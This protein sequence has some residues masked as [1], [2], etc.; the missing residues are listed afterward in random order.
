MSPIDAGFL[1]LESR[2]H[3]MHVGGL[4][5][6]VP[7]AG[8]DSADFARGV[9]E[10]FLS[11]GSVRDPFRNKPWQL[12]SNFAPLRW[13]TDGDIDLE[14]HV[15][16]LALP[17]P[18]RVRELLELISML[19]GTLL[20]R[21]RPLWEVYVIEGLEDGRV[22]VFSKNHHALMDGVS[23]VRSWFRCLSPDPESTDGRAPWQ[24]GRRKGDRPAG[25]GPNPLA[26][27]VRATRDVAGI[28]PAMLDSGLRML[29]H[30]DA[31]LPFRAPRTL[32]NVPITGARRFAAQ[33]WSIDRIRAVGQ[34]FG[35]T[36][37]D[38]VLAMCSGALRRYL[39][40]MAQLPDQPLIAMIPVS[41]RKKGDSDTGNAVGAVLC[42]LGTEL[43]APVD[44]LRR[45][46]GSMSRAKKSMDGRTTLQITAL[47]GLNI[48]GL[49][50]Q[51]VPGGA[52]VVD[53]PAFNLVISNVPGPTEPQ[54]WNGA[55][56]ESCY[57]A[58]IP[59]DGQAMNI[60]LISYGGWLHF[61][62]VGCRRS[63]PRL[64]RMLGHL[65]ASLA[66]LEQATADRRARA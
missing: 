31:A 66:E 22:A 38:V 23:A 46:H 3:P 6:F 44:R 10:A 28:G 14:Y 51:W 5:L 11:D 45:V 56:L 36:I 7:P 63:V 54:Y 58:S 15:R 17:R 8:V 47:S 33:S 60:T 48:A 32:F 62:L 2:E 24:A 12:L 43:G 27:A 29:R 65:E 1:M 35:V 13:A 40:E 26:A 55:R 57:P 25:G 59:V 21:H 16:L 49:G 4:S 61:G 52:Q 34:G 18:G 50:L 53:R 39:L 37:N 9:Y 42:D 30:S 64:Q 19:H 20:D 41:L